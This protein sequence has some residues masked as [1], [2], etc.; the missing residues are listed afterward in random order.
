MILQALNDVYQK[1]LNNPEVDI[2]PP[3]FQYIEFDY[4]IQLRENGS[5]GGFISLADEKGNLRRFLVP[6]AVKRAAGVAAN[7]LWDKPDYIFLLIDSEKA[8]HVKRA[9]DRCEAFSKRIREL[10]GDKPEDQGVAAVLKFISTPSPNELIQQHPLW[11]SI[12]EDGRNLCFIYEEDAL[13]VTHRPSVRKVLEE[14]AR[15]E[16]EPTNK[17][18]CLV[19]GHRAVSA[20]LHPAI[21]NVWGAQSAG[22][23]IVSFNLSAFRSYGHEKGDNAPVSEAATF[24]Y[25]TVLNHFLRKGSR[26]RMQVGDASTVFWCSEPGNPIEDEFAALFNN[27]A[28]VGG[29]ADKQADDVQPVRDLLKA[30]HNGTL[31]EADEQNNFYVLGLGPNASRIVIR[32]W[33]AGRVN[34]I[35]RQIALHF[36][37]IALDVGA[38]RSSH[39][40]LYFLL[41][42]TAVQGK[43]ENIAPNL[44]GNVMKAILNGQPYPRIFMQHALLRTRAEQNVTQERAAI[45]KAYVNRMIRANYIK[46]KEV[47]MGLDTTNE[48]IGYLLGRLFAVYEKSQEDALGSS[49]NRGRYYSGASSSPSSVFHQLQKMNIH[50]LRKLLRDHPDWHW[51]HEAWLTEIN[52][53]LPSK[54]FPA[55]LKPEEQCLFG[56]GYYHQRQKFFESKKNVNASNN[57]GE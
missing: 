9:H 37:D 31:P 45:M 14:S 46:G 53:K 17:H 43:A 1:L 55:Y 8:R 34:T 11:Q 52:N 3:G 27:E 41:R 23:N 25:T 54:Q 22:A 49:S 38:N 33:H 16:D 57:E 24:A 26:Q 50:H 56:V 20:R 10:F 48:N 36:D 15:S 35:R 39:P 7:L 21:K 5:F 6:E 12:V 40:A 28:Q 30:V 18:Q 51:N 13:P 47:T 4:A 42:S 19:T 44:G 29:K 2:A 32:F